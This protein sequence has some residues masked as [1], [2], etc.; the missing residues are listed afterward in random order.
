MNASALH[1]DWETYFEAVDAHSGLNLEGKIVKVV[2]LIAEGHGVGMSIGSRCLI[3]NDLGETLTAEVVGFKEDRVLLMPYGDTRGIRPGSRI[4]LLDR[5]PYVDAGDEFLGRV[6]DGMGNPIDGKGTIRAT[7]QYPLYGAS[8]NPLERRPIRELMDV[9]V[10]AINTMVPLGKGQR[11]AIMAG[12]G[13]G[14]S[15]LMGMMTRHTAGGCDGGGAHRGAG[16]GSEGFC[17]RQPGGDGYEAGRG[18]GG[19]LRFA[20]AGQDAGGVPCHNPG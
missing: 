16:Q 7:H 9:G 1:I 8:I 19:H 2:G 13:V 20:P 12:S 17:G 10:T 18:G 14:K 15:V 3:E 5:Y 11:V 6:V 4:A